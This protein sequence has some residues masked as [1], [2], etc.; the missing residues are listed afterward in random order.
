MPTYEFK[1]KDC[2]YQFSVLVSL[3]DRDKVTCP[4]CRSKNIIQL[5]SS[6]SVGRNTSC[7]NTRTSYGGGGG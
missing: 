2:D 1:C 3:N 7:G 6:Y 4:N 5:I